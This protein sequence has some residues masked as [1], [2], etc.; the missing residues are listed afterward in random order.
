MI[1]KVL[2][3]CDL[4]HNAPY[5]REP[6]TLVLRMGEEWKDF[7]HP[8]PEIP[9]ADLVELAEIAYKEEYGREAP[10]VTCPTNDEY[11]R[12]LEILKAIQDD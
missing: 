2:V 10:K 3:E 7:I 8:Y 9:L 6:L 4:P 11:D 1:R 5:G 12:K